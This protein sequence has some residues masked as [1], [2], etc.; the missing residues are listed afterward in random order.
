[1]RNHRHYF[2]IDQ[3]ACVL[4]V[5]SSGYY[6][7]LNR[8]QNERSFRNEKLV[9]KIKNIHK[10]SHQTYGSPRI[11]AEL[12]QDGE[13]CS[14]QRVARLMKSYCQMLCLTIN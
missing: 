14:R 13:S 2:S 3:M 10:A 8:K 1:M 12:I 5:S 4:G 11:H 6:N 7:F 9:T